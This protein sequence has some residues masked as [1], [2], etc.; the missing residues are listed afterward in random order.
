MSDLTPTVEAIGRMHFEGNI[1]PHT[2]YKAITFP[3]GKADV[4]AILILAEIVYWYRPTIERD[5]ATGEVVSVRKKFRDD[6]LQ[7]HY[8]S[9]AEQ[10]GLT[11][12]Q[13]QD[14]I[15]RLVNLK[16][17]RRELRTVD[18]PQGKLGNVPYFE[19][20]VEAIQRISY[21][22]T[23][24]EGTRSN[25]IALA[26]HGETYTKNK[27]T[28]TSQRNRVRPH[29]AQPQ[30]RSYRPPADVDPLSR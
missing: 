7:R 6:M 17:I 2:W 24:G 30:S 1:I 15:G 16:L 28:K 29:R 10:F 3:N 18:T 4:N 26:P 23:T 5:E 14:A 22:V 9:F 12:R 25:V 8:S 11:K 27:D 20:V 13:C 21:H 19:P